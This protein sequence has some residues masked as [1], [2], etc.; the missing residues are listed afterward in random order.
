V[1]NPPKAETARLI[2]PVTG[3]AFRKPRGHEHVSQPPLEKQ[4]KDG[5]KETL[6]HERS[7]RSLKLG[8]SAERLAVQAGCGYGKAGGD[9]SR[10]LKSLREMQEWERV[11]GEDG[12]RGTAAFQQGK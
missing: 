3:G 8:S 4:P 12:S 10:M 7:P 2:P 11:R 6:F 5:N 9:V 1:R